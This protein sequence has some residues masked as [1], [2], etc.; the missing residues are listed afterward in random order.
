MFKLTVKG[1]KDTVNLLDKF[2]EEINSEVEKITE[3][4]AKNIEL[5]AIIKAPY[6]L[7]GLRQ[8][9]KSEAVKGSKKKYEITAHPF[10]AAYVEFGTGTMVEVPTE[11]LKLAEEFKADP[12]IR[13]V[14][15]PA[16]PYLYPSFVDGREDF[17]N[18]LKKLLKEKTKK[19]E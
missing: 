16:R 11:L 15:L 6:D 18:K 12:K 8:G 17:L 1:I 4:V 2:G 19:N 3:K 14:N 10:Y 7:G 13:E 5:N 9:I